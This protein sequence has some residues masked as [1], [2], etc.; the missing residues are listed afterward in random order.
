MEVL[1]FPPRKGFKIMVNEHNRIMVPMVFLTETKLGAADLKWV[2]GVRVRESF[3]I[4]LL[5]GGKPNRGW[6]GPEMS[7][8]DGATFPQKLWWAVD[9]AKSRLSTDNVGT[10]YDA[11]VLKVQKPAGGLFSNDQWRYLLHFKD[12]NKE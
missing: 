5:E 4:D 9:E 12:Y 8:E 1:A 3:D 7:G 10:M 6:L 11:E 2:N